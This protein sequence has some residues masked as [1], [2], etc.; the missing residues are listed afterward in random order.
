[1]K[2]QNSVTLL[3]Q[4]LSQNFLSS[5]KIDDSTIVIDHELRANILFNAFKD[6]LG[7]FDISAIS[8]RSPHSAN[9]LAYF[10]MDYF[11]MRRY[12]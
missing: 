8:Y 3:H 9:R 7:C 4:E 6:K 12:N 1:M 11:Q 10:W 2:T 5:L